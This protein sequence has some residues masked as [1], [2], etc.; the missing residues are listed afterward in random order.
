MILRVPRWASCMLSRLVVS[1]VNATRRV[2]VRTFDEVV[3]PHEATSLRVLATGHERELRD[4]E[5]LRLRRVE[6][7]AGGRAT[8]SHVCHDGPDFVRPL[9]R[10]DQ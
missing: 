6:L 3:P 4:L 9:H 8:G 1:F 2:R 5:P 10:N 7:V